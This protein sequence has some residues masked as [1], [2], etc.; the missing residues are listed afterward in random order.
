MKEPL[1]IEPSRMTFSIVNAES[2]TA[3]VAICGGLEMRMVGV[4]RRELTNL[5]RVHP[6]RVEVDMSAC[7]S[8]TMLESSF[9]CPSSET[10]LRR[11]GGSS[12]TASALSRWRASRRPCWKLLWPLRIPSTRTSGRRGEPCDLHSEIGHANGRFIAPSIESPSPSWLMVCAG[13]T[14]SMF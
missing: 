5:L 11:A 6:A 2:N 7:G 13:R 8:S 14:L 9:C 1:V 12:C 3:R 10:S 4:F